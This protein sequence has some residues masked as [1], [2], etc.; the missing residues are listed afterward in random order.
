MPLG[1]WAGPAG[2]RLEGCRGKGHVRERNNR[3][4]FTVLM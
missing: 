3:N 2:G 1:F 4:L